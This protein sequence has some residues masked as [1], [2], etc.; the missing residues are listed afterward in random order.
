MA[1]KL[2]GVL[3]RLGITSIIDPRYAKVVVIVDDSSHYIKLTKLVAP[4][5]ITITIWYVLCYLVIM[6]SLLY[7]IERKTG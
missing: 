4:I 2:Y 6:E 7:L 3:W 5:V 1:K